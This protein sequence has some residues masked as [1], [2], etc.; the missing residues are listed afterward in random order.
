MKQTLL[1]TFVYTTLVSL[2]ITPLQADNLQLKQ[3]AK[4]KSQAE[5]KSKEIEPYLSPPAAITKGNQ[6]KSQSQLLPRK[7][8]PIKTQPAQMNAPQFIKPSQSASQIKSPTISSPGRPT[9]PTSHTNTPQ[10]GFTKG[11][12]THTPTTSGSPSRSG[13]TINSVGGPVT[14]DSTVFIHPSKEGGESG[15]TINSVGGPVTQDSTVFIH[16]SKEGGESGPTINSVGGPVTQD[17]TVFIHP[18]KEGGESGP[19]INSVNGTATTKLE[20]SIAPKTQSSAAGGFYGKVVTSTSSTGESTFTLPNGQQIPQRGPDGSMGTPDDKGGVLYADGTYV[21]GGRKGQQTTVFNADG[22]VR[23][24]TPSPGSNNNGPVTTGSAAPSAIDIA[25]KTQSSA[26]GGFYG[27]VVTSTSS[28]G[29]ST[30]TLPN[31]Q[32][33]PQRGPDGS[34]GTPDDKGG[35]LY[36]DGTYVS[37]GRK[38]QQTTV[39]NADGTVRSETPSPGSNNNDDNSSNNSSDSKESSNNNNDND[40]SDD[41]NDD[42]SNSSDDSNDSDDSNEDTSDSSDSDTGTTDEDTDDSAAEGQT[43]HEMGTDPTRSYRSDG[44]DYVDSK[45]QP[46]QRETESIT[47]PDCGDGQGGQVM[48]P[49]PGQNGCGSG[50]GVSEDDDTESAP[51]L[52]QAPTNTVGPDSV[53]QP[54]FD[55]D[56]MHDQG[57]A[58]LERLQDDL[59]S[60]TNPSGP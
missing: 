46:G 8:E 11:N 14:Q 36:A 49:Q 40:N 56:T 30:F 37:G 31:G 5:I 1:A 48:E 15:P 54:G 47:P 17:S 59:D 57:V 52:W 22:T 50:P 25:P 39:F 13:P 26:A 18:S 44:K 9:Q 24:T 27:K 12:T 51:P 3:D 6:L 10:A 58:P 32:Q 20:P 29:E 34:M 7:L 28:T 19:T 23:S 16:P 43:G 41:D 42:D 4:L 53:V 38:G 33:I 35:V 55:D 60:I 21:S 2:P 45:T